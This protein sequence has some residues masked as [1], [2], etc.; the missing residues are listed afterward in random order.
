MREEEEEE[1]GGEKDSAFSDEIS[2]SCASDSRLGSPLFPFL[3]VFFSFFSFFLRGGEGEAIV[4]GGDTG[5]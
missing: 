5:G 3:G 1:E 4:L 2:A